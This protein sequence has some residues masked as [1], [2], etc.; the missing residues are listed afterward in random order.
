MSIYLHNTL[1]KQKQK[2]IPQDSKRVSMYVCG[3]TVY[4]YAHIGNARPAVVFDVLVRLLRKHF[5]E[6]VYVRNLTDVDDKINAAAAK[7]GVAINV[8]TERY[9]EI[10]HQDMAA[11]NVALPDIEPKATEHMAEIIIMIESLIAKGFAYE[12]EGHVLFDVAKFS[13]YGELSGRKIEDMLAGARVEVAAFKREA[14][15]FVLWKPSTPEQP[16]WPSP[17]GEG[18][19]GWHIECSAMIERH[20]GQS[21]DIHGGGQDLIFPHH[22]NE[23]AQSICAHDGA[24][25]C[26]YWLHNGF[27]NVNHEKMS[28]SIG[29]VLLL[30]ELLESAPGEAVRYALLSTHYRSPLD[31]TDELLSSS[32]KSLDRLYRA[33]DELDDVE[34][35]EGKAVNAELVAK[36]EQALCDD[37]NTPLAMSELH[38]LAKQSNIE[39]DAERRAELKTALIEC[40]EQLGLLQVKPAVWFGASI[41]D[42]AMIDDLLLQRQQ[43]RL[44][45]NYAR[46][47]EIRNQ[48]LAMNIEIIDKAEGTSWRKR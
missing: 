19:P 32:K 41:D 25:Y 14:A 43:A 35:V 45:K 21:I 1:K 3:P 9:T 40:S 22:E 16:A 20:L 23:I 4:S 47:D 7:E 12:A 27:V 5:E 6:V 46:A 33:L 42:A 38:V 37:I 39:T 31:W 17:W 13:D 10:Y 34:T 30:K 29:N 36:F 2:F 26:N 11:L 24:P 48:L 15:D 44:D 8:I 18:R 28:K